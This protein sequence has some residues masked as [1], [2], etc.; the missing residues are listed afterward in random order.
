MKTVEKPD[1]STLT[2]DLAASD[3]SAGFGPI[4]RNRRFLI[5][6]GGQVFSQLA[7]K[8]YLILAIALVAQ[9][10]QQ[11]GQDIGHWV[12]AI[13]IAFT[14]PAILFGSLAGAFV[15]RWPKKSVLVWSNFLRG[16]LVWSIPLAIAGAGNLELF[17][18]VPLG[19]VLLLV[20]VFLVSTL[21]Q[22][23]A[24]AEQAIVPLLVR[25]EQLLSANSLYSTTM[26]ASVIVGF[27]I[28]EPLLQIARIVG[29]RLGLA[30]ELAP[31]AIVGGAYA[32]AGLLLLSLRA[33]ERGAKSKL[34]A[35]SAPSVW[36]RYPRWRALSPGG[37]SDP[38]S[39]PFR[40]SFSLAF[41]QP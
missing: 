15:D 25:R 8:V 11:P 31:E 20:M 28:G 29:E 9:H 10:F 19:F 30:S 12:S 39:G 1:D 27:A 33:S 17:A 34:D 32:I 21:T 35:T 23:F 6:W 37:A 40:L 4:L 5:L 36:G 14:L 13:M 38:G 24:P 41:L 18:G 7:D 16:A 3:S 22:F 26:M 2:P